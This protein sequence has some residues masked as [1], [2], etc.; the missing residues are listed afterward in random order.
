MKKLLIILFTIVSLSSVGQSSASDFLRLAIKYIDS[1]NFSTALINCNK[2]VVLDSAMAT[3]WYLRGFVKY[4]VDDYNGAINDLN[5][6]LDRD[7]EFIEAYYYRGLSHNER[8]NYWKAYR[9][10]Q[11]AQDIIPHNTY[12]LLIKGVLQNIFGSDESS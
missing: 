3:G 6:T 9:D 7:E 12:A 8:G 2:A 5:A 11:K 4:K 10:L 1:G